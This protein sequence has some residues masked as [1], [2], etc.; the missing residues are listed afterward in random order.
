MEIK[1]NDLLH[2]SGADI[3][4]SKILKLSIPNGSFGKNSEDIFMKDK[5]PSA[6]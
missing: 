6:F 2:F 5:L 3:F 4:I 1:L